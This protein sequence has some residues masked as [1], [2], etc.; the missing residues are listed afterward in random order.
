MLNVTT[1][2]KCFDLI[3]RSHK[4]K[5]IFVFVDFE[6][7][8]ARAD[9]HSFISSTSVE[10]QL[11]PCQISMMEPLVKTINGFELLHILAKELHEKCLA[12]S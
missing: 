1:I 4:T 10:I 11:R 3:F 8:L 6:L 12:R 7:R 9:E 2:L 5:N